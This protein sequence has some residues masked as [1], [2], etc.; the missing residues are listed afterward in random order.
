M[1]RGWRTDGPTG[2]RRSRWDGIIIITIIIIIIT[3]IIISIIVSIIIKCGR[4][5]SFGLIRY[6]ITNAV[7]N[8]DKMVD[9]HCLI[10][11]DRKYSGANIYVGGLLSWQFTILATNH[12]FLEKSKHFLRNSKHLFRTSKKHQK[13]ILFLPR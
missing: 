13:P 9:D 7:Q 11:R 2:A 6:L 12:V 3:I 5:D 10:T 1:A 8:K 4:T